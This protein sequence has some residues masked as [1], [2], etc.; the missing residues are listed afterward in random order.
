MWYVI[1]SNELY[2]H[3][4]KGQK[5]G[6]RRFQNPDGTLTLE[7]RR[8][9]V[10]EQDGSL[11]KKTTSEKRKERKA[12]RKRLKSGVSQKEFSDASLRLKKRE[13]ELSDIEYDYYD[14]Y[15]EKYI[16]DDGDF[17]YDKADNDLRKTKKYKEVR[18]NVEVA[19]KEVK[20]YE[21]AFYYDLKLA[22]PTNAEKILSGIGTLA[23][24]GLVSAGAT[25]LATK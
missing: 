3:G 13:N 23:V 20:K 19:K 5:W 10:T 21:D 15:Y 24:A 2:H 7:G 9:Y 25:Y 4:I 18:A 8:R 16:T 11:R 6:V 22:S 1:N 17:D 14:K 12:A